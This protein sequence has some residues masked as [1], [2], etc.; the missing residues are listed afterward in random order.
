MLA[1]GLLV[2]C[3]VLAFAGSPGLGLGLRLGLG[4]GGGRAV[5][6]KAKNLYYVCERRGA[7]GV[8]GPGL[9][10][11]RE[12][13]SCCETFREVSSRGRAVDHHREILIGQARASDRFKR[14]E[15]S[16]V[17]YRT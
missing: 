17:G 12:E 4:A 1:F 6:R 14:Q 3:A 2:C 10:A 15:W 5:W 13:P 7:G 11:G 9:C 16:I 8:P